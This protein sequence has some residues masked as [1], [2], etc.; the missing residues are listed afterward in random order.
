MFAQQLDL[1]RRLEPEQVAG[2][3]VDADQLE[4]LKGRFSSWAAELRSTP[5]QPG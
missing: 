1:V 3:G 4:A 5:A 2:Y